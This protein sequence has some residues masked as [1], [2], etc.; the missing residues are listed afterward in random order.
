MVFRI[1]VAVLDKGA[2]IACAQRLAAK[3]RRDAVSVIVRMK[4]HQ[5]QV[6]DGALG[7]YS[8]DRVALN[9]NFNVFRDLAG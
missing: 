1:R 4:E 6:L 5:L 7:H 8:G 9:F 2:A 3:H